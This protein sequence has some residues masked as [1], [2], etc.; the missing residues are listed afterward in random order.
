MGQNTLKS[1]TKNYK[2][3]S[4]AWAVLGQQIEPPL[5][6][7]PVLGQGDRAICRLLQLH[8]GSAMGTIAAFSPV[9]IPSLLQ[10]WDSLEVFSAIVP[11]A[12][13]QLLLH[14]DSWVR[15]VSTEQPE[16]NGLF[17]I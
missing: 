17:R 4:L 16:Q 10:T 5:L 9:L 12:E 13:T 1:L 7:V 2:I 15:S 11:G 14:W 3:G 8:M 6:S